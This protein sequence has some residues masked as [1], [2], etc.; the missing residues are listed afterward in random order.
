MQ[1]AT[2]ERTQFIREAMWMKV[3]VL[4]VLCCASFS[5]GATQFNLNFVHST[6]KVIVTDYYYMLEYSVVRGNGGAQNEPS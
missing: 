3:I 2:T 6:N 4:A 1:R 5:D